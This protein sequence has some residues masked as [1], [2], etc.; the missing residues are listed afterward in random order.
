M[1]VIKFLL[2]FQALL[3]IYMVYKADYYT[4]TAMLS[5]ILSILCI[6]TAILL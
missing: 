1:L 2:L 3:A 4:F 6:F 5:A